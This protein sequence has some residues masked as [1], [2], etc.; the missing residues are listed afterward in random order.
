LWEAA[1]DTPSY[2]ANFQ[3]P[4]SKTWDY[5]IPTT[6]QGVHDRAFSKSYVAVLKPPVSD[7]VHKGIDEIMAGAEKEWIDE[8]EGV[9][10]YRYET[11]L[12]VMRRI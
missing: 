12:Y 6:V 2:K 9:F 11:F 8:K 7:E 3:A 1:F 5:I 10:N 4:E